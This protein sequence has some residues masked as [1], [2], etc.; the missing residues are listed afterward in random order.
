VSQKTDIQV[1]KEG[2]Q[3]DA[4]AVVGAIYGGIMGA[5]NA[6]RMELNR[7]FVFLIRDRTTNALLFIGVVADPAQS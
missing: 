7:P 4:E 2:I 1:N 5:Q 6:F 3:A